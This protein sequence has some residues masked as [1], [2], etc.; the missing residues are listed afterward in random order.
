MESVVCMI[1]SLH[2]T[3]L[4]ETFSQYAM[5]YESRHKKACILGF[6]P[7]DRN[8]HGLVPSE[9]TQRLGI[10]NTETIDVNPSSPANNNEPL[11]L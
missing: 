4:S 3:V 10:S 2:R 6:Q 9:S 11:S 1:A 5:L 7:G 8:L